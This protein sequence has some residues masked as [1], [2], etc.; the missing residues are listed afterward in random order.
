MCINLSSCRRVKFAQKRRFFRSDRRHD[1][2]LS[3]SRASPVHLPVL[4]EQRESKGSASPRLQ[5]VPKIAPRWDISGHS[6]AFPQ[7]NTQKW[8]KVGKSGEFRTILQLRHYLASRHLGSS[9]SI[10]ILKSQHSKIQ[11]IFPPHAPRREILGKSE[12]NL[13]TLRSSLLPV[14]REQR[15][16]KGWGGY[17]H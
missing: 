4:S 6:G 12:K 15:E 5:D 1:D 10:E 11:P 2:K 13:K 16:S 7:N 9:T 14:L 8:G 3:C 17:V